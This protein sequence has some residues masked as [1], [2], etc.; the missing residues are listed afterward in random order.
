MIAMT[1]L[2]TRLL[3][4]MTKHP[5]AARVLALAVLVAG[6]VLLAEAP[7]HADEKDVGDIDNQLDQVTDSHGIPA[8]KYTVLPYDRGDLL[9]W[10]KMANS[11][12]INTAWDNNYFTLKQT[13]WGLKWTLSFQW[14]DIVSAPAT[15]FAKGIVGILDQIHI[16]PL[17][18]LITAIVSGLMIWKG[19][20][21][22][23]FATLMI[24]VLFAIAAGPTGLLHNPVASIVGSDG[25]IQHAADAGGQIAVRVTHDGPLPAG[26]TDSVSTMIDKSVS[27]QLVDIFLRTP[28]QLI[29]FG[30]VLDGDCATKFD[31][32][33][34]NASTGDG[35]DTSVRDAVAG[36][37]KDAD[38]FIKNPNGQL[39]TLWVVS[40]S[41]GCLSA[42]ALAL[43]LILFF[44]VVLAA[45]QALSLIWQAVLACFPSADRASIW[46]TACDV[47]M[48]LA[49]VGAAVVFLSAYLRFVIMYM[50]STAFMG[51]GQYVLVNALFIGGIVLA[52]RMKK[53]LGKFGKKMAERFARLG[54]GTP[55][56]P[57]DRTPI[58]PL[59]AA[60]S[61]ARFGADAKRLMPKL[62]KSELLPK[63]DSSI[64]NTTKPRSIKE[65]N[66]PWGSFGSPSASGGSGSP[67]S[68]SGVARVR[69]FAKSGAKTA[70][71]VA[72]VAPTPWAPAARAASTGLKIAEASQG[73]LRVGAAVTKALPGSAP[74]G[75]RALPASSSHSSVPP[76]FVPSSS[77]RVVSSNV[78]PQAP[79]SGVIRSGRNEKL[80]AEISSLRARAADS[81]K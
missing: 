53:G 47:V 66:L 5:I 42:L 80:R 29:S 51:V 30:K 52:V 81:G 61:A 34:K 26:S 59:Q 75:S 49:M 69:A 67:S 16:I 15:L 13:I 39:I 36:C 10:D 14:V 3:R 65:P 44:T 76:R 48:A 71:K 31:D 79:P 55:T 2:S 24:S 68:S 72:S 23:G 18:L 28:A 46:Y 73:A 58:N 54:I 56:A 1:Q 37:D 20:R 63:W 38:N 60:A 22:T 50:T 41:M 19:R 25:G 9:H 6:L 12:W 7:A 57:K 32:A 43:I 4:W 45:Y 11:W 40:F 70:L 27:Q 33:M 74:T 17:A 8:D 35:G 78:G 21:A 62:P 64:P 77:V